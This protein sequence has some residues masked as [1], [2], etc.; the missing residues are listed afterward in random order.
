LL[1]QQ[2]G[3]AGIL[4]SAL[5]LADRADSVMALANGSPTFIRYSPYGHREQAGLLPGLPG[6]NGEHPDPLTGHYLLG[7]G[8]RAFNPVLMRFNGPDSL[9]PFGKG[10]VNAYAYCAG[11]PVNRSDPSGHEFIDTLIT[12]IYIGAGLLTAVIG[13]AGARTSVAALF[14]GMKGTPMTTAAKVSALVPLT[15][16][17]AGATWTSAFVVRTIDPESPAARPLAALAVGFT[18]PTLFMRGGLFIRAEIAARRAAA[19]IRGTT[20]STRL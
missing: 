3:S 7:N 6:F 13:L 18:L 5:L 16:L 4:R 1:A 15:A 10:G 11:D 8:Y 19:G 17:A 12:G 9:S 14:N 20:Y 2:E